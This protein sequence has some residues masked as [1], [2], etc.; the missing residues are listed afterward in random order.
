MKKMWIIVIIVILI[1]LSLGSLLLN[2]KKVDIKINSIKRMHLSYSTGTMKD[3]NVQYDLY[4]QQGNYY[5]SVKPNDL[6][7]EETKVIEIDSKTLDKI[8]D[9]LNEYNVS[10]WNNFH[11]FDKNVLD[12]DSF[13]FNLTTQDDKRIEASGYMTYPKD[14]G[15]VCGSLDTIFMEL[16]NNN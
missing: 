11:K 6:S 8:I 15:K 5:A 9:L 4:E 13:S 16:Y 1:V 2:N 7:E 14:Y 3:S 12:G 10:S